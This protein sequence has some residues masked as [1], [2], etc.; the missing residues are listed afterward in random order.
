[1]KLEPKH[2]E[3]HIALGAYNAVVV[4]Q[5]GSLVG[6]LTYGA[7]KDGALHHFDTALKLCPGSAIARIEFANGLAMLFGKSRL[8]IA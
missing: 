8:A 3:A 4:K 7:S 2:A 6:S 5:L 1:M